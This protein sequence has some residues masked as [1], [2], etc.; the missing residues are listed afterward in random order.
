MMR[1]RNFLE[2]TGVASGAGLFILKPFKSRSILNVEGL[3]S[4]PTTL[5]R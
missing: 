4:G 1:K 2:Y 5:N 3:N